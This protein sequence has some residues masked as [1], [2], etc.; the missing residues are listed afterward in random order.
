MDAPPPALDLSFALPA[1]PDAVFAAWTEADQVTAWWGES[2]VY[3][4]TAWTA[5]VRVGGAWHAH[6]NDVSGDV[7]NAEGRY[8]EVER[9]GRLVWTWRS[10]WEPQV[11]STLDMSI[12]VAPGGSMLVLRQSGFASAGSRDD[13][14]EVWPQ[15][16]DWLRDYLAAQPR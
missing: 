6:F 2:G 16:V 5:D 9:P 14:A 1:P 4:T 8:L 13:S 11:E 15:V 10:S 3:R 12:A 7:S